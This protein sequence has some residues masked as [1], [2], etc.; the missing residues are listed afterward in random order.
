MSS[1]DQIP[2]LDFSAPRRLTGMANRALTA[3]QTT[4][5]SVLKEHWH[6]LLGSG[7]DLE[8]GL[9]DST[10]ASKAVRALPDP[11]FAAKLAVGPE[12]FP[13]FFVFSARLVQI[14]RAHV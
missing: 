6:G 14:G 5:C 10:I 8:A 11:G 3:W 9:V 12:G 4:A 13:A 1:T 2:N 7:V